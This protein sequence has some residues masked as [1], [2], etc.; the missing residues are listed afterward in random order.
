MAMAERLVARLKEERWSVFIDRDTPVGS[1]WHQKIES[2]LEAARAVVVLWSAASRDSDYVLEEAEYGKKNGI[3]FPVCIESVKP[4]YGFRRIQTADLK[5]WDNGADHAGLTQLLIP[6]RQHLNGYASASPIAAEAIETE[7]ILTP[8]LSALGRTFRDKLNTGGEGPLMVTIPAG[9]FLMGSLQDEQDRYS[10][11]DPQ[12]EVHIAQPFALGVYPVTFDDYDLFCKQSDRERPNDENWG[13]GNRP[14]INVSWYDARDYCMWLSD[15]TGCDYR[16]PSEAEWE[17]ACRSGTQT[18]F[19]FGSTLAEDKA[20]FKRSV[21][22]TTPVGDYPANAFGLYDMHGNVWE[23][24]E[25]AWHKDY[26]G[27][28]ADGL[29]WLGDRN[30]RVLRGGSWG[31]RARALRAATRY[32][33]LP[34]YRDDGF[35]FRCARGQ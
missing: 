14:V 31:D 2:E 5:G 34:E 21:G 11:E 15:Q 27:A 24:C 7:T 10:D 4:P 13:R 26:H 23:W 22:K 8:A 33:S 29:A 1:R 35:G 12:Y 28:P 16:L 32:D 3:L 17:Y 19:F 30:R 25:D 6:L 20:N 18:P 9:R